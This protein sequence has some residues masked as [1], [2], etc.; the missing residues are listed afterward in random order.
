VTFLQFVRPAIL[1]M[2]GASGLGLPT[3]PAKLATDVRNESER[4]HYIRGT[5]ENGSFVP[6][7][8]QESHA[9][10]GLSQSNGLLRVAAGES[11]NAGDLVEVQIWD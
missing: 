1:K 4:P 3:I 10:F 8:R 11:L 2:I 5:A 7:G 6:I 9:L